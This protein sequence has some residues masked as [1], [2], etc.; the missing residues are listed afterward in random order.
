[1]AA[2]VAASLNK[3]F[4][5]MSATTTTTTTTTTST[6][7]REHR[8]SSSAS[9]PTVAAGGSSATQRKTFSIEDDFMHGATASS[10]HVQIRMDFMR[11]VYAIV[12]SQLMA[13]AIV[14]AL[15]MTMPALSLFLVANPWVLKV[16]SIS[17]IIVVFA[18]GVVRHR[19]PLNVALLAAMTLLLS[20]SVGFTVS[21]FSVA[22]V[23]KA[24]VI[25]A[26][27]FFGLT[28][29]TFQTK[30][31]FTPLNSTLFCVLNLFIVLSFIQLFFPFDS[32]MQMLLSVC[33][34]LLFCAFIVVDTQLLMNKLSAD[35]YILCAVNLYLDILN[36]F[37]YILRIVGDRK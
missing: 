8:F 4:G 25:T 15:F 11:K 12:A 3:A 5:G 22:S 16:T 10:C 20:V 2:T 6:A 37:I 35:E 13:T 31:D 23:V 18:L 36:L 21:M 19:Y 28:A 27:L 34:A 17:S 30:Y 32:G 7:S 29:F 1:M 26:G 33:G 14:S 24:V 9:A